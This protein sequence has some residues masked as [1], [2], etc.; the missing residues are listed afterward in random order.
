MNVANFTKEYL[1]EELTYL[2]EGFS[3]QESREDRAKRVERVKSLIV[4]RPELCREVDLL[5]RVPLHQAVEHGAPIDVLELLVSIHPQALTIS[6]GMYHFNPLQSACYWTRYTDLAVF[7]LL[8][9]PEA[10]RNQDVDGD[11][12]L[13]NYSATNGDETLDLEVVRLLVEAYPEGLWARGDGGCTCLHFTLKMPSEADI[14]AI[15]FLVESYPGGLLEKN[16]VGLT[17]FDWACLN[18]SDNSLPVIRYLAEAYPHVLTKEDGRTQLHVLCGGESEISVPVARLLV[19][20][21][22]DSVR[23][24]DSGGRTPL[25][26]LCRYAK[27]EDLP[28]ISLLVDSCP[29]ILK[30]KDSRGRTPL[31]TACLGDTK[32]VD[33]IRLLAEK[34]P[35]ILE[36]NDESDDGTPLHIMCSSRKFRFDAQSTQLECLQ[37]LAVSENAVTAKDNIGRSPLHLLS[38]QGASRN[39]LHVL[40]DKCPAV[41]CKTDSHGRIPL[42]AAVEGCVQSPASEAPLYNDTVKCLL[43]SFPGGAQAK[44]NDG[45]T[46]L[47]LACEKDV[48]LSLVYQLVCVDPVSNLGLGARPQQATRKRK[49]ALMVG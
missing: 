44:D 23:A 30:M 25:N 18:P 2:I 43:E 46:P 49:W 39:A 36:N 24:L 47:E 35:D 15:R 5:L 13:H 4:H 37:V 33:V 9:S 31:H 11:I 10:A 38:R 3:H 29:E 45:M 40:I 16:N 22:P 1:S 48:S 7:R 6:G 41:V 34:C 12:A 8:A 21:H 26:L 17:P 19:E 42:H 27:K 14:P 28:I 20:V 32:D